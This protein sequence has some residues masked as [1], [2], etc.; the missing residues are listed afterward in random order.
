MDTD[1]NYV[2]GLLIAGFAIPSIVSAYSDSRPPRAGAIA[3]MVG[4]GLVA[5][6]VI[7][8]PG[9]YSIRSTPDAF[10]RVVGHYIN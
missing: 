2:I 6:A 8:S 9:T 3:L 7:N 5:L 1:L 10:V 4:A